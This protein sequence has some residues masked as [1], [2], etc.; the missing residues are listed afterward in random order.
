[1]I[2]QPTERRR[3]R[4][5]WINEWKERAYSAGHPRGIELILPD[6]CYA[7]VMMDA[8]LAFFILEI[9]LFV[10]LIEFNLTTLAGFVLIPFG[11][12]GLAVIAC[13]RRCHCPA[14]GC[15]VNR[16]RDCSRSRVPPRSASALC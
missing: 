9:Q 13:R 5:S 4:F 7:G 8:L 14:F 15:L 12:F 10:T 6:W 2:R 1:M 3:H 11:L 16:S